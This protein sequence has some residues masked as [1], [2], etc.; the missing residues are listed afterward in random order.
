MNKILLSLAVSF[1]F[2]A[3][4]AEAN[5]LKDY[6][7]QK[8]SDRTRVDDDNCEAEYIKSCQAKCSAKDAACPKTCKKDA[9]GFCEERDS[10][11]NWKIAETVGKGATLGA[12]A[13]GMIFDD[14]MSEVSADGTVQISPYSLI[15]N[16]SSFVV[17]GGFGLIEAGAK[18]FAGTM[19]YRNGNYG[20]GGTVEHLFQDDEKLTEADLGPTFS[21]G[22]AN[23]LFT[24]QPSLNISAGNDV[25]TEYGGGLRTNTMF[26]MDRAFLVGNPLLYYINSQWGYHLRVGFGYRFTPAFFGTVSYEYRDILDLNDLEVS[27]ARLQGAFLYLGY[28]YN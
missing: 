11:R 28:R 8:H 22:T 19:Y 23:I 20:F 10:R 18:A 17:E 25:A 26:L 15:F 12:G 7:K 27:Q 3:G 6:K 14:K 16:K 2:S 13:V 5:T 4:L 24:L 21:F 1:L 9:P